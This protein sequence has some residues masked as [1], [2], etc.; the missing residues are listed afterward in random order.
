MSS[1]GAGGPAEGRMR[2]AD[3]HM[4]A[5]ILAYRAGASVEPRTTSPAGTASPARYSPSNGTTTPRPPRSAG[6]P[7][8]PISASYLP[9]SPGTT[10]GNAPAPGS[11][12][13][14]GELT[15]PT[16]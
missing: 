2:A 12:M 3:H 14:P 13:I 11:M 15:G 5:D 16:T 9:G 4:P 8:G 10:P 1:H 6:N 7:P